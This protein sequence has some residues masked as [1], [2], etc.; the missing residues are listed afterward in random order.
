MVPWKIFVD[1]QSESS[2]PGGRTEGTTLSDG[3]EGSA[4]DN[5]AK[6]FSWRVAGE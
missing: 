2:V 4:G 1:Q 6:S 3:G 5:Q